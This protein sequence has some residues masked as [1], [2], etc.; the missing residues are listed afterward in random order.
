MCLHCVCEHEVVKTQ[1]LSFVE[2]GQ[3]TIYKHAVR[4]NQSDSFECKIV[5]K[6]Y[7]GACAMSGNV[8][9]P[10]S[11]VRDKYPFIR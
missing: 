7:S 4:V 3:H 11:G 5:D 10:Q 2:V 1:L 9:S 8:G 6:T